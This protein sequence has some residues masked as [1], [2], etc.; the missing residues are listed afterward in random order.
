MESPYLPVLLH[1]ELGLGYHEL[2]ILE[3]AGAIVR[4]GKQM[5]G[6][7]RPTTMMLEM[8]GLSS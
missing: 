5:H 7:F 6:R 2:P 8:L 3:V 4:D 1:Y